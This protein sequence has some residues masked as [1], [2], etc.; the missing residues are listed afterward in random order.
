MTVGEKIQFYRKKSGLSQEELGQ[1][2]LVSRQTVSLWEMDKTLPTVDN[3][4]RLKEIFSVSIDD[5][6]NDAEPSEPTEEEPKEKYVFRYEKAELD[7]L[8]KKLRSPTL[9]LLIFSLIFDLVLIVVSCAARGGF[10]NGLVLGV[11]LLFTLFLYLGFRNARKTQ[12]ANDAAVL[13]RTY[14]YEVYDD[15]FVV[16]ITRNEEIV[17]LRQVLFSEVKQVRTIGN[18]LLLESGGQH[19][20]FKRDA[21]IPDSAIAAL[22]APSPGR[23]ATPAPRDRYRKLS[24]LF[25]LLPI[26]SI[27]AGF[28]A[29]GFAASL[30]GTDRT[31]WVF[32][33]FLPVPLAAIAVGILLKKKG[34]RYQKN[35]VVGIVTAL[36]LCGL[37]SIHFW[38]PDPYTHGDE[39]VLRAEEMLEIDIPEYSRIDTFD[40]TKGTQSPGRDYIL[41]TSDVLFD[42]SAVGEFEKNLAGDAKWIDRIPNDLIG[43]TSSYFDAFDGDYYLVFNEDTKEFNAPPGENGTYTFLGVLWDAEEN[44]MRLVEYRIEYVK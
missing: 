28:L 4:I 6:L 8:S 23:G 5:M 44:V 15:R 26:F 9:K 17:T 3:L 34:R 41:S 2:M 32:F 1:K 11:C 36:I 27:F 31:T 38:L 13:E 40:W 10:F 18:V 39:P 42:E 43:V 37:G 30:L 7:E 21:L 22:Q 33:L 16:R 14:F 25:I 29:G 19:F 35:L 24:D 12:S 20:M